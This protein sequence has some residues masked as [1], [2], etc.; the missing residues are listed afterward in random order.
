MKVY[1]FYLEQVGY[2]DVGELVLLLICVWMLVCFFESK[3]FMIMFCCK[4]YGYFVVY[5][6]DLYQDY[7]CGL[8]Y[9]FLCVGKIKKVKDV[10]IMG[11]VEGVMLVVVFVFL[12]IELVLVVVV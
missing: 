12:G 6:L 4:C 3:M 9:M 1:K 2:N 7:L 5:C 8:C 10:V 11:L